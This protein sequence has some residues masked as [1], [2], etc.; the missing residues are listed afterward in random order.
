MQAKLQR[1]ILFILFTLLLPA[2]AEVA[3]LIVYDS[4]DGHTEQLAHWVAEGVRGEH[5]AVLRFKE[6]K[7]A[8]PAD[9][10]WADAILVGSPVYNAGLTPDTSR[11]L[12]EWPFK[13][14]PLK[15]KVGGAFVTA[16]GAS[17]GAETAIFTI[18]RTMLIFQMVVFGGD[19]WRSGFG[20]SHI[21]DIEDP[22]VLEFTKDKARRLGR[23]ACLVARNTEG[24]RQG[25]R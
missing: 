20:V 17:A 19:D 2:S 15:N 9:L 8:T 10:V 7:D 23:R 24:M 22:K 16:Q 18:L 21:L 13:E 14:N 1:F 12:A 25:K 11:F 6:I 5:D 3:V 4:V